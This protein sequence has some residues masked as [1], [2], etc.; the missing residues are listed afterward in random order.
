MAG[1]QPA[2]VASAVDGK[3]AVR[4]DG[5]A[6]FLNFALPIQGSSAMTMYVVSSNSA[7]FAGSANGNVP[8]AVAWNAATLNGSTFL[9]PLQSVVK[10]NF[11]STDAVTP[12]VSRKSIGNAFTATLLIKSEIA[13]RVAVNDVIV[14]GANTAE[15]VISGSAASAFLGKGIA[16]GTFFPGQIAEVLVYNRALTAQERQQIEQYL[17]ARYPSLR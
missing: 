14:Y 11:G 1:A 5:A 3:P 2:L 10:W 12:P 13:E 15:P 4:F 6:S 7:P 9:S 16:P 17:E 8:T